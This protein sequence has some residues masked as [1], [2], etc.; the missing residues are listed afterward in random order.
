MLLSGILWARSEEF[1]AFGESSVCVPPT[2]PMRWPP[3]GT[4]QPL[5]T[6]RKGQR[7]QRPPVLLLPSTTNPSQ[8]RAMFPLLIP[9]PLARSVHD[10]RDL[11]GNTQTWLLSS[12]SQH[13]LTPQG[14]P[15]NL[16]SLERAGPVQHHLRVTEMRVFPPSSRGQTSGLP[17]AVFLT[18]KCGC[19]S[20][21][22]CL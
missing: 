12:W 21:H 13:S 11:S 20:G 19:P 7:F 15:Q 18:G 10:T 14:S 8:P 22:T 2:T 17:V 4:P 9:A 16:C 1:D 6:G 5:Y 3:D